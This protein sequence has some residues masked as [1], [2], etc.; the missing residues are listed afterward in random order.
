MRFIHLYLFGYFALVIGAG[1]AL[2]RA[3]ILHQVALRWTVLTAA[4]AIGLGLLLFVT[5][6]RRPAP[7]ASEQS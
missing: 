2:W 7:A 6:A 4:V 5:S 1:L 3:G